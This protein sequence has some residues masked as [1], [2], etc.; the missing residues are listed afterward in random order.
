MERSITCPQCGLTSHN[1]NDIRAKYCGHCHKFHADMRSADSSPE[2]DTEESQWSVEPADPS[3]GIF[4]DT[5]VHEACP[6]EY[7]EGCTYESSYSGRYVERGMIYST[8]TISVECLDCGATTSMS[9]PSFMGYE[10][11]QGV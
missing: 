1:P 7:E 2:R 9:Q 11:E 4:G 10:G 3:V 6:E 8:E 5:V